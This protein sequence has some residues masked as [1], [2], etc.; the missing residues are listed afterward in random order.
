MCFCDDRDAC[1]DGRGVMVMGNR[2]DTQI[3]II[4]WTLG[5]FQALAGRGITGSWSTD[6]I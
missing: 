3:R 5:A 4:M 1:N 2:S 6:V